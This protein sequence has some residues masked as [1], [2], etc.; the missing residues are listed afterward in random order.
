[1]PIEDILVYHEETKHH[2]NR[3][4]R[5]PGYLDWQNQPNPFRFYQGTDRI[6]LPFLKEDP[7]LPYSDLYTPAKV[8]PQPL[9][10]ASVAAFLEL[11][12][13]LS[14][15]KSNGVGRWSLRINPSS[16]NL[17]PTE[18]HL[19]LPAGVTEA[20]GIFHYVPLW[21]LLELRTVIPS[22]LWSRVAQH[23]NSDGFLMA[24]T[25][26]FWREAWKYGERAFR[27][28]QLD[29][30]HA[31]G[32]LSFAARI[33]GWSLTALGDLSDLQ[34]QTLLGFKAIGWQPAD[35][36][37]PDLLCWVS[38]QAE[39]EPIF[40][41]PDSIIASFGLLPNCGQPNKLSAESTTWDLITDAAHASRKP[42][43]VTVLP[44][45]TARTP[46]PTA[47]TDVA[48]TAARVIRKRR[49]AQNYDKN[50]KITVDQFLSILEQTHSRPGC[51]PFNPF[52]DFCRIDLF[53]FVHQVEDFT[54]GL[55][56]FLRDEAR[57][58]ALKGAAAQEFAWSKP[59]A[60][61]PL[62]FLSEGDYRVTAIEA[63][64]FQEIAGFSAFSLGM[65]AALPRA[66]QD[67]PYRYRHLFWEAGMI[68][69]SLYL[70][71]EAH[72]LRGTGIGC[73]FD[74]EIHDLIGFQDNSFQ[75]LYHFTIGHPV[76][77]ERL[78]TLTPYHHIPKTGGEK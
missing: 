63:S 47:G 77:D 35:Q 72:G 69:Q 46:P 36:E 29:V 67:A 22:A 1:M 23:F 45:I 15:W 17:H 51:P 78:T 52:P 55:Y 57:L 59:Y 4:A 58:D 19:L 50:R 60:G 61:V 10:I 74:D 16:G 6:H 62:Y 27:Y 24:L 25:S 13:A 53:L 34:I 41:L 3:M 75:S 49:S 21:H 7:E 32:C 65:I 14:A 31:I 11:S 26:I 48:L 54:P 70:G 28:C 5:S 66:V 76:E 9:T 38:T 18:M 44:E 40:D 12:L 73:Y 37:H 20:C 64:C 56:F 43:T 68:G 39:V 8:R 30:G 42:R 33:N 2:R 71:A